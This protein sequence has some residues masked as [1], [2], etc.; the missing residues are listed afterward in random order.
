[1]IQLGQESFYG[2]N[3]MR[4]HLIAG[5]LFAF[6]ASD[7]SA[8]EAVPR[9]GQSVLSRVTIGVP[10]LTRHFPGNDQF[11]NQNWGVLF[12]VAFIKEWSAVGGYFRNSYRRDT[13]FAGVGWYPITIPIA[14]AELDFG[15]I[16][17]LD[18]SGGYKGYNR[19]YPLLGALSLKIHH[20]GAA[21][22]GAGPLQRLG[23]A[24]TLLPAVSDRASTAVNLSLT[25]RL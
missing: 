15:G 23:V 18:L 14:Q 8:E 1:M 4:L 7:A 12:D 10:V 11:N 2:S 19:A 21:E 16:G 5:A 6:M 9:N 24:V 3:C 20:V 22:I 13:V 17:A 25:Y